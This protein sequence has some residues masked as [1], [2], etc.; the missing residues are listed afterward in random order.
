MQIKLNICKYLNSV[1]NHNIANRF[2]KNVA[3]F[4]YLRI[5]VTNQN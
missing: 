2:L 5:V 3:E 4:R 1:Q